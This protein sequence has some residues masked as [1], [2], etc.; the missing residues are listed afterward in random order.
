MFSKL[1]DF[2]AYDTGDW[3]SFVG[4]VLTIIGFAITFLGVFRAASAAD[5][6]QAAVAN[7]REDIQR[8]NLVATF[9]AAIAVMDEIKRLHRQR[10]WD[11]ALLLDRYA[12]IRKALVSVKSANPEMSNHHKTALQSSIQHFTDI[13]ETVEQALATRTDP[14]DIP[15]LN[16]IVAE[17][18][19]NVQEILAEVQAQIGE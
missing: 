13:E 8:T 3:L 9:T 6:A 18:A 16:R 4:L 1:L 5:R 7:V 2:A 19:D 15:R 11:Y 10:D 12:T 14:P 17:Q